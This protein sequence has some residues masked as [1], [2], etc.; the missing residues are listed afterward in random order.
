MKKKKLV[1]NHY[2]LEQIL[3]RTVAMETAMTKKVKSL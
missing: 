3:K 2:I 1:K